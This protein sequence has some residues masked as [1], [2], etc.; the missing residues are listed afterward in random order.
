GARVA[1]EAVAP[2]V[3]AELRRAGSPRAAFATASG[4]PREHRGDLLNFIRLGPWLDRF[5]PQPDRVAPPLAVPAKEGGQA[6]PGLFDQIV[7]PVVLVGTSYSAGELWSFEDC[8]KAAL[9]ADVLS[10]AE[11]GQGPLVPMQALLQGAVL[12]D[13]QADV[14]I[15]EIPERY[16]HSPPP[17]R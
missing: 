12:S 1:A 9:Q 4:E 3:R 14:V 13:V 7:I 10:V 15:W 8:L 16:F 2:R 6:E 11:E 5:G 17:A